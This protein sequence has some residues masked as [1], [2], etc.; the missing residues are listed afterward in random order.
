MTTNKEKYPQPIGNRVLIKIKQKS[1]EKINGIYVLESESDEV[2]YGTV[3]MLGTGKF[4]KKGNLI[5]FE[6][7]IGDEIIYQQ[8]MDFIN[9]TLDGNVYGIVRQE[10]ILGVVNNESSVW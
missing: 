1:E 6:I 10:E 5:P 3:L 7:N 9:V 4:N 2:K 8:T